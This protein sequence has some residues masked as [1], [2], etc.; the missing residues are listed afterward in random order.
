MRGLVDSTQRGLA[1]LGNPGQYKG[2]GGNIF[3][4]MT[5]T[6]RHV[7]GSDD[8][9]HVVRCRCGWARSGTHRDCKN[10]EQLHL[11]SDGPRDTACC[12]RC[13]TI[14][15]QARAAIAALREPTMDMLAQFASADSFEWQNAIDEALR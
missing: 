14:A 1:R 5:H 10:A 15:V 2:G 4:G 9:N 6:V 13:A 8:N 12:G 3:M 11:R 7:A